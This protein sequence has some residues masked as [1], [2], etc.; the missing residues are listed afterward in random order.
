MEYDIVI[1]NLKKIEIP[2]FDEISFCIDYDKRLLYCFGASSNL[3]KIK[4]AIR[5]TF[6]IQ[7]VYNNT[8]VTPVTILEKF[9]S[10]NSN[11]E[12]NELIIKRFEYKKGIHG[13]FIAQVSDQKMARKLIEDYV[14]EIQKISLSILENEEYH[15][16]ISSNNTLAINCEEDDFYL[17]LEKIKNKIYA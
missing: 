9:I 12:I 13:K 14:N 6:N 10:N 16:I 2:I 1:N 4:T 11:I 8:E 5:N 17:I 3:N 7:F 15:L